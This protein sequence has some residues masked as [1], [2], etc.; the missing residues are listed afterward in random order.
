MTFQPGDKVMVIRGDVHQ[1]YAEGLY[2]D[3]R[4]AAEVWNLHGYVHPSG[5]D[6]PAEHHV[7][8]FHFTLT[9]TEMTIP[10]QDLMHVS[11]DVLA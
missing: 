6:T 4:L 11:N 1:R 7:V 8:Y 5:P 9:Y 2:G 3:L 10:S